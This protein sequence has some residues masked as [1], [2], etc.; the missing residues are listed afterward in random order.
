M[1][2]KTEKPGLLS[3]ELLPVWGEQMKSFW[4]FVGAIGKRALAT[5][6]PCQQVSLPGAAAWRGAAQSWEEAERGGEKRP[7]QA[8]PPALG[9]LWPYHVQSVSRSFQLRFVVETTRT[10]ERVV[11]LGLRRA[12]WGG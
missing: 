2:L 8:S 10:Q 9:L 4:H 6:S 7:L 12:S 5:G 11:T 1:T 3:R